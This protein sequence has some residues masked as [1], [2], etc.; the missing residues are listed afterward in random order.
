M[1]VGFVAVF[2]SAQD[3]NG[4]FHIR[5]VDQHFLETA[6]EG[7]I[8]FKKFLVLIKRGGANGPELTACQCRFQDIGSIH[9]TFPAAGA[10]QGMDLIDEKHDLAVTAGYFVDNTL[11]AFLKFA[12]VF[13][14]CDQLAHVESI[15]HFGFQ[16]LRYVAIHDAVS[17]AFGDGRFTHTGF[18]H[19]NGVV[20]IPAGEN[21]QGT[22]YLLVASD[23]GIELAGSGQL[24]EA[25]GI[26]VQG[27]ELG[28]AALGRNSGS[29]FEVFDGGDQAFL[30]KSGVFEQLGRIVAALGK[31]EKEMFNADKFV[32]KSFERRCSAKDHVVKLAADNLCGLSALQGRKPAQAFVE[33]GFNK[34]QVN[35]V[36]LEQELHRAVVL[37]E[38]DFQQVLGL[39]V[40][41]VVVESKL[42]CFLHGFLRLDGEII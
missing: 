40:R 20:L 25:L 27:V 14:A 32:F 9:C 39:D 4:I 18:A 15:D 42:L 6:F 33:L 41:V 11:E 13:G 31:G 30:G 22:A 12:L 28:L 5:L 23:H 10:Y 34:V 1:V 38:Q 26:F 19:Q 21:V 37:A 16:V 2:K 17:Q 35:V 36:F 24:V 8:L 29:L 3:G 7:F